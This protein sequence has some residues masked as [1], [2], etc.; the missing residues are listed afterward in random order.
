MYEFITESLPCSLIGMNK[1]LMTQYIKYVADRLLLMLGLEEVY[2]VHNPFEWMELISVQ[3]KTNF[4]E[5]R[6]GEYANKSNPNSENDNA[7][8]IDEDF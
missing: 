8:S 2:N 1:D 6:V 5:K 4:F 7:F 3:G